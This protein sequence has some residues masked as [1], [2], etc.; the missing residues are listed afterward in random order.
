MSPSRS[1]AARSSCGDAGEGPR[2][3]P[4]ACTTAAQTIAP[5]MVS[6]RDRLRLFFRQGD[7]AG[8]ELQGQLQVRVFVARECHGVLACIARGAVMLPARPDGVQEPLEAE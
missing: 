4:C 8:I 5:A 2:S 3:G 1:M 7:F 6:L